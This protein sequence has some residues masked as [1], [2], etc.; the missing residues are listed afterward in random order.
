MKGEEVKR[1]QVSLGRSLVVW[2][3]GQILVDRQGLF[4]IREALNLCVGRRE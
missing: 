4:R 1:G 3:N 2:E